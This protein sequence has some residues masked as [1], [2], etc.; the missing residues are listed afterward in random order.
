MTDGLALPWFTMI[1]VFTDIM[2]YRTS[3][4]SFVEESR[5]IYI[6]MHPKLKIE[7]SINMM[8]RPLKLYG[9]WLIC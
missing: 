5:S 1:P 3:K 7:S 6:E 2:N 8:I 9:I 4:F